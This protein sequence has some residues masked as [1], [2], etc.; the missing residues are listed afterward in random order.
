MII[1]LKIIYQAVCSLMFC[2]IRPLNIINDWIKYEF[3]STLIFN[4]MPGLQ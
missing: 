2:D 3:F 4:G 1:D